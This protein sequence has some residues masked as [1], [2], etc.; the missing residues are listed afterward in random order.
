MAS[1]SPLSH[2]G[3][4]IVRYRVWLLLG[5]AGL[6]L[7]VLVWALASY[8]LYP[9]YLDH[10]EPSV[11]L[12]SFRILD[13][14]PAYPGFDEPGMVSSVYGP[15]T[16]VMHALAI[17]V[18][19]PSVLS[20]KAA[21][22]LAALLIPFFVFL[23]HR[24]WGVEA[25]AGGAI[26]AAGL[27]LLH[28]PYSIWNRPD[29]II[30]LLGVIAVWAANASDPE[31]PEW[32]KSVLIALTGGL[33]VG[34]KIHAGIY[35]APVVIFHCLNENRGIKAFMAMS[36][37]GMAVVLLPF[38]FSV[39]SIS[40]YLAWFGLIANK[41]NPAG[42]LFKVVRY[43]L[44]Y[45]IPGLF[46]LAALKEGKKT[47][48]A[49]E[50]A[51]FWIFIVCL[52]AVIYPASK[53]GAGAHYF[54]P[55]LAV[56]VDQIFRH[57]HRVKKYQGRVM[58]GI[59]VL[60]AVILI[61]SVPV[62][63]RFYQSLHWREIGAIQAEIRLIMAKYPDRTIEMGVGEDVANYYRTFYKSLLVLE[64]HPYTLD[65]APVMET[66]MMKIPLTGDTL[67]MIRGCNTDLWLIPK[68]ERPFNMDSYYGNPMFD[69]DFL[70][71]F[72]GSYAKA[73]SFEFFDVWGCRE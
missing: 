4:L 49:P 2:A 41:A 42:L 47:V 9:G 69:E 72:R 66:S 56:F 12:I 64:G 10:G 40:N 16:F 14:V 52:V 34:F 35:F 18:L 6:F 30:A 33:A 59:G 19:G 45:L 54:F 27:V 44:I 46:F 48:P 21:S 55:F 71:A 68:D 22:I 31:K 28:I 20:G 70:G 17:G 32:S 61:L 37:V 7:L 73:E 51:Y 1:P 65:A 58:A 50:I 13:G 53:T 15:L 26:F 11:T 23:S 36:A 43:G 5:L 8:I 24:S 57:A 38:A 3:E 62:Q 67:A 39:F 25:A 63:K 60:A 29:S